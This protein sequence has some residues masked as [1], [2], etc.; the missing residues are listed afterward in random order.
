MEIEEETES[1][2]R[3]VTGISCYAEEKCTTV[4]NS[5][6][7]RSGELFPGRPLVRPR[8]CF[9]NA[10][11]GEGWNTECSKSY[12]HRA[13]HTPGLFAI[14][15]V[16]NR[17][18]ILGVSVMAESESISTAL[19]TLL[20][21]FSILPDVTFYDNGCNFARSVRL[22]LP[23]VLNETTVLMDRF[24]YRSHR[25]CSL[26]DPDTFQFCDTLLTSGAEALNR[27]LAASRTHIRYLSGENLI[28]FLY[29]RT[30]FLNLRARLRQDSN[31]DDIE[32][33]DIQLY[34]NEIVPCT[35]ARC[36]EKTM[37]K[38]DQNND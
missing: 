5:A 10:S 20:T 2:G 34:F 23:W 9:K 24:H 6:A 19:S 16:C 28:P 1:R 25:C 30:L 27:R 22:R 14:M 4:S 26:F 38:V 35:C 31:K 17:P 33:S 7:A 11:S 29:V 21:R 18:K 3:E 12:R 37:K 32:D 8:I 15:C 36:T 13:S